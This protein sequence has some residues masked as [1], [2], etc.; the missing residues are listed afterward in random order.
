MSPKRLQ[1]T[2]ELKTTNMKTHDINMHKETVP[3][4]SVKGPEVIPQFDSFEQTVLEPFQQDDWLQIILGTIWH[5]S[6]ADWQ[7]WGTSIEEPLQWVA[8]YTPTWIHPKS[9]GD[10]IYPPSLFTD[11]F[12]EVT[13]VRLT[14]H[15]LEG[16]ISVWLIVHK[17]EICNPK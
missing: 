3:F 2:I 9:Y 7:W 4:L 11:F 8:V 6:E 16:F 13:S 5:R 14:V 10:I 17:L 12:R 1:F 15:R